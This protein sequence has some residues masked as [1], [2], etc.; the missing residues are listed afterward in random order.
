MGESL[1]GIRQS[2]HHTTIGFEQLIGITLSVR[3]TLKADTKQG[4][5]PGCQIMRIPGERRPRNQ[6]QLRGQKPHGN[7]KIG[8]GRGLRW[9]TRRTDRACR[10]NPLSAYC[11]VRTPVSELC[12]QQPSS[13]LRVGVGRRVR[14][15]AATGPTPAACPACASTAD[16]SQPS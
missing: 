15:G 7:T 10:L 16:L 12:C 6:T 4:K 3:L 14:R 5:R 2:L 1:S 9:Q 8:Q 13:G 11:Y